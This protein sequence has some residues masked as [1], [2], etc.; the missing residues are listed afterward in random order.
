MWPILFHRLTWEFASAKTN[1]I[2]KYGQDLEKN[3]GEWTGEAEIRTRKK[4][5]HWL[6]ILTCSVLLRE[7]I[8]Q[9]WVFNR[10]NFNISASTVPNNKDTLRQRETESYNMLNCSNNKTIYGNGF[11]CHNKWVAKR[12]GHRNLEF[13]IVHLLEPAPQTQ[14]ATAHLQ[15]TWTVYFDGQGTQKLPCGKIPGGGGG[16]GVL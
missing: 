11:F 1:A 10:G 16:G 6:S 13:H 15:T 8:P 9:V 5:W 3:E 7:N 4:L 14:T 12:Q 2:E